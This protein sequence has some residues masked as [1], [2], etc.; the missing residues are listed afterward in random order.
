MQQIADWLETLGMSEYAERFAE[1]DIDTS[2]RCCPVVTRILDAGGTI[3]GKT[4]T[5]DCSFSGGGHTCVAGPMRNPRKPTHSPGGS[6]G[7][8]AAAVAAGD[9]KMALGADQAGSIRMPASR[10]ESLVTSQ[11]SGSFPT[12]ASS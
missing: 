3:V 12:P 11:R 10:C 7:G 4:N 8:S 6:S 1:S 9:V 2:V 5:E